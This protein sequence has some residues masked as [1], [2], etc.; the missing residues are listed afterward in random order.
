MRAGDAVLFKN[1][2]ADQGPF[3]LDGGLYDI[4]VIATFGGG[5]VKLEMLM[6]DQST[7]AE[8]DSTNTSFTAA[9]HYAVLLAPGQYKFGIA[10]A[11]AVY[12][13]ASRIPGE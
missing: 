9:G 7:Y 6:P 13:S 1:V 2:A 4:A 5:S 11:T 10:T 12:V 3:Y 8:V